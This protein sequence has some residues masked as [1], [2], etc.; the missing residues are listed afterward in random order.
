MWWEGIGINKEHCFCEEAEEA[1]VRKSGCIVSKV[2][3]AGVFSVS[4]SVWRNN[5]QTELKM[6]LPRDSHVHCVCFWKQY[7]STGN[8]CMSLQLQ[9][10]PV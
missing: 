5:Y 9:F 3:L 7:G 2:L 4:L 10:N 8:G 6:Q 1:K